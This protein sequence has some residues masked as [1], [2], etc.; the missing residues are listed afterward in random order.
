MAATL[1]ID[2]D[3][4]IR[5]LKAQFKKSRFY[6]GKLPTTYRDKNFGDWWKDVMTS[7]FKCRQAYVAAPVI[8]G[9]KEKIEELKNSGKF[10]VKILTANGFK[11]FAREFTLEFLRKNNI[12]SDD[13]EVIFVNSGKEKP[14]FLKENP[15][16]LVDDKLETVMA[17]E[18]PSVGIWIQSGLTDE[19]PTFDMW[20]TKQPKL[21]FE[22]LADLEVK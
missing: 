15:G 19:T 13:S 8:E 9:A 17:V 4:V 14:N 12:I 18:A 7:E 10:N 2:V 22:S 6:K 5:D 11:P 21:M 1:Y 20:E 16:I 3:G